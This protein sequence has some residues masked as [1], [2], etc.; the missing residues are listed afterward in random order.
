MT[1]IEKIVN[2]ERYPLDRLDSDDGRAFVDA[3]HAQLD[4]SGACLL[5]DF[6]QPAALEQALTEADAVVGQGFQVDHYFAYDD[7]GDAKLREPIESLPPDHPRRYRSL[8][9]IRF[10]ARDLI[11]D[12]SPVRALHDWDGMT[13]FIGEVM[14][15][16][17]IYP[18]AC[19]LSSC[20]YTVAEDG[21]LQDWHF[22]GNEFIVTLMLEAAAEGGHFEYVTGLRNPARGDDFEQIAGVLGGNHDRVLCPPIV[23]GTLTLFRGR[24]NLHRASP[25]SPGSRR[26]MAILSYENRPGVTGTP[27]YLKLF[28]GRSLADL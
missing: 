15:M 12:A 2:L 27:D 21:E 22:D 14:R 5:P 11:D 1:G 19:P 23:P 9:R 6:I 28:Y 8:T 13:R 24:Y 26:I 7:D 3:C 16:S 17:P 18:S 20:I 4:A 25:V 10:V